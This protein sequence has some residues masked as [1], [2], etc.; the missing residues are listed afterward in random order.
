MSEPLSIRL[1]QLP[2]QAVLRLEQVVEVDLAVTDK[3]LLEHSPLQVAMAVMHQPTV[4]PAVAAVAPL[5]L[6]VLLLAVR[7]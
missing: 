2:M 5:F 4:G 3:P 6:V 1:E 7:F